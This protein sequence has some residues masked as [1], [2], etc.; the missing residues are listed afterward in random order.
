[1]T[2]A[3]VTADPPG[4]AAPARSGGVSETRRAQGRLGLALALPTV[5]ILGVF[6]V[7]PLLSAVYFAFTNWDGASIAAHLN[8]LSNVREMLGDSEAWHAL[9]NNAI[10][11]VIGT[12]SPMIIGLLLS[13]VLWSRV[14][15]VL[16]FRLIYFLPFVLPSVAVAIVWGW[17][18]DPINGWLNRFLTFLG[19]GTLTHG[20]LGEPGTALYAVLLAAIWSTF[21]FVVVIFL[22][23][24]QNVDLELIDAARIDG[25]NAGQRLWH[26]IL[27]QITPVFITVT[28]LILVGGFSVFDIVFIMTGG[29]PGNASDVLGVYA[30]Q[31]AFELNRVGY[32]TALALAITVLSLPCV[33]VLNRLQQ[34]LSARSA[35]SET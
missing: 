29:G 12:V 28:T 24:L 7:F 34:R 35:G 31:N 17:I 33:V 23:A 5:I 3:T 32:G 21:G 10:W 26:V 22:A 16:L 1:M 18:Y 19:L 15:G 30:Y 25:A 27:P 9:R 8:G 6:F 2:V 11:I 13:V 14:R 4:R 20:W